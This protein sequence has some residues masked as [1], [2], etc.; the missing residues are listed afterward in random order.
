MKTYIWAVDAGHAWLA[1]KTKELDELNI[2]D[3]ITDFSYIKGATV[4]LE[5]DSDAATFINA[6]TAKHG[7]KPKT[8]QGKYWDRQPCRSF[9]RYTAQNK[10]Q[11]VMTTQAGRHL[12]DYVDQRSR[13]MA[14][15]NS[16]DAITFPLTQES[17]DSICSQLDGDLSPENLHCDGEISHSQAQA[18][19]RFYKLV[20]DELA[21]YAHHN[22]L[23][24]RELYEL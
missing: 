16:N 13:W 2:A 18:K 11:P 22:G 19:Y 1:V 12:V 17:F 5:E 21:D 15:F 4:Y 14:I 3:K 20:A 6:Y 9:A 10:Q 7:V 23:Q 8:K 24:M